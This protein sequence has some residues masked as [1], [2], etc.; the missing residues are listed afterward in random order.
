MAQNALMRPWNFEVA[1]VGNF[2]QPVMQGID[3]GMK[4]RQVAVENER[5]N[6][7]MQFRQ[8]DQNMQKA[9]FSREED[10]AKRTMF[11]KAMTALASQPPEV[12]AQYAPQIFAKHP[13]YTAELTQNGVPL[14]NPQVAVQMLAQQ[15]GDYDKLAQEQKRA[16]IEASKAS[17][18]SSYASTAATNAQ[19]QQLSR[20]TPEWRQANAQRYGIDI[21]TPEGKAF[22]ISGQYTPKSDI[23]TVKENERPMR[24]SRDAAGNPVYTPIDT[25]TTGED[26]SEFRKYAAQQDAKRY[27]ELV[28]DGNKSRLN[29]GDIGRLDELSARIGQLGKGAD[30]VRALGPYA[31]ALGIKVDGLDDIQAFS[32]ITSRLAPTMR[33]PGSGA[34]SDFEFKQFLNALPQMSQTENGRKLV[35]DQLRAMNEYKIAAGEISDRVLNGSMTR[36][37]GQQALKGLGNPL[38][39]WRQKNPADPQAQAQPQPGQPTINPAAVVQGI[40]QKIQSGEINPQALIAEAE[41]AIASGK[42]REAVMQR[43]Q[44]LLGQSAQPAR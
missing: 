23:V 28:D 27:G 34:T 36:V 10:N 16:Q 30:V 40:Q 37:Q 11:G 4:D 39:L 44:Q 3:A 43:L 25:G 6:K 41:Q 29:A 35:L 42:P 17:T 38:M 32:A 21:N 12:V 5:Q 31:N 33:P 18:A 14:N 13:E 2:T 19:A 26:N 8:E 15:Y 9:R 7:L 20:Q 1:N 22:V 24:V